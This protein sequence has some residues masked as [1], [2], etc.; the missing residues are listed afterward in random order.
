[1][2]N[3]TCKGPET[4]KGLECLKSSEQSVWLKREKRGKIGR[5]EEEAGPGHHGN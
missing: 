4:A 3:D 5:W 2:E 1:M